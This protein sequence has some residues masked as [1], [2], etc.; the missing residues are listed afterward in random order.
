[1]FPVIPA[2]AAV[3]RIKEVFKP[4]ERVGEVARLVGLQILFLGKCKQ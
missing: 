1:M 4:A 3:Q 2:M